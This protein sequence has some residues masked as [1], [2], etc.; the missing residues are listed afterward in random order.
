MKTKIFLIIFIGLILSMPVMNGWGDQAESTQ[1]VI[2]ENT[3]STN[4][5]GFRMLIAPSGQ[6]KVT[7]YGK[8]SLNLVYANGDWGV[9]PELVKKLVDDL[10]TVMPLSK[11]K[12]NGCVK[13][14]SFG[15]KTYVIYKGQ[16]SADIQ[17]METEDFLNDIDAIMRRIPARAHATRIN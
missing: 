13:S 3:G 17:C 4:F 9:P 10:N 7:P 12:T 14:D 8:K 11:L 1:G 16:T 6:V 5:S 15:S 2:V